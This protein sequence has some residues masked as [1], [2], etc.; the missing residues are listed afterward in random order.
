MNGFQSL[1]RL[2]FEDHQSIDEKVSSEAHIE[3]LAPE[4]HGHGDLANDIVSA[5]FQFSSQ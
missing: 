4:A 5:L 3:G 1:H 2:E